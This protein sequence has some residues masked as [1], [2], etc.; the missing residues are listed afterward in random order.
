MHK[1]LIKIII[2]ISFITMTICSASAY[3][4]SGN[5][6]NS[7][8]VV[9]T[10]SGDSSAITTT[11]VS[12]YYEFSGLEAGNYSIT[13]SKP[14]TPP[15]IDIINPE[16]G[17]AV[18]GIVPVYIDVQ[19]DICAYE[20][21]PIE[22]SYVLTS[23]EINQDFQL[24]ATACC[25]EVTGV[26]F[27]VDGI[28]LHTD[29]MPAM[30]QGNYTYLWNTL[31]Y[32][33]GAHE[34][35]VVAYDN[36]VDSGN[37]KCSVVVNNANIVGDSNCDSII[38]IIDALMT[39][40][41]YV[42]LDLALFDPAV[43]DVNLDLHNNIVDALLIAQYYVGLISSL[44]QE[45]P[46]GYGV[47]T[48]TDSI[49]REAYTFLISELEVTN[50]NIVLQDIKLSFIQVVAGYNIRFVC[51]YLDTNTNKVDFLEAVVFCNTQSIPTELSSLNLDIYNLPVYKKQYKV[52]VLGRG[53]DC[54]DT[55]LVEFLCCKPEIAEYIGSTNSVSGSSG[56]YYANNLPQQCKREGIVI[57]IK[58]RKTNPDEIQVCT[59]LGPGYNHIF[60]VEAE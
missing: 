21:D 8:G 10:L 32:T 16:P 9:L 48:S 26:D 15:V 53:I 7:A 25:F 23:D 54:G 49:V 22:R 55:Y 4:I 47:I 14:Y 57:D 36:S 56:I 19:T 60:I 59:T 42:G 12:G 17:D 58:F 45:M 29:T 18:L 41:Y 31:S 6:P 44:P 28:L 38:N 37:G 43:S 1:D 20:F 51:S 35:K 46:G 50:P 33:D 24:I 40:Q 2:I 39:A 5:I 52:K 3:T 11:D 30:C 27:Y 34:V 13:P